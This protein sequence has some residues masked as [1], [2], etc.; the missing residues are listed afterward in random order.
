MN[1]IICLDDKNGILFNHRRQ[2]RDGAL[3]QRALELSKDSKLWMNEYSSKLF[4]AENICVCEDFLDKANEGDFCFVES[5][6]F[7]EYIENAEKIIVYR[8][9]KTYPS[10][11]KIDGAIFSQ[12]KLVSSV[13][14]AGT[15][16]DKITEEIYE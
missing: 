5:D 12:K 8:W 15:S 16:H 4:S 6:K 14:F 9:N 11:V 7:L 3:C 2:S 13:D 10:D 1:I